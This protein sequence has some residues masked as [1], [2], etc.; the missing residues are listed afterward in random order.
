MVLGD[1]KVTVLEWPPNSPDLSPIENAWAIV[2]EIIKKKNFRSFGT[3]QAGLINE[4]NGIG[5]KV[6][7]SLIDSMPKRLELVLASNG[8]RIEY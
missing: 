5:L 3:F 4:W 7:R 6:L 2:S 8:E 1:M